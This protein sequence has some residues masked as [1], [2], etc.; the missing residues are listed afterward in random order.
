MEASMKRVKREE[1]T[2]E[3]VVT[4]FRYRL[5]RWYVLWWRLSVP[6]GGFESWPQ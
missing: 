4:I 2:R 5:N 1:M 6:E 3:D